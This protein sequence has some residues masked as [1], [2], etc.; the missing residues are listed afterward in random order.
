ME[1]NFNEIEYLK[2]GNEKQIRVYE[3]LN[4][5]CILNALLAFDPIIVGTIPIGIDIDSSDIDI[6][7]HFTNEKLFSE[8][9]T[10]SFNDKEGFE[11]R[12]HR[13]RNTNA[14]IANF[15]IENFE[16]EIFG[17]NLPTRC[18][19]AY[20]HMIIEYKLLKQKGEA[21][22]KQVI[23]LKRQG[24]KTEPAFALLLGLE[25]DPYTALLNI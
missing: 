15:K 13:G 17:Q 24:L 4:R 12:Q 22:R 9:L 8:R 11:I 3:V 10:S 20:R 19:L 6:I 7:C 21:F 16:I 5:Y 25:G 1:I 23:E 18:Q 14:M 2:H